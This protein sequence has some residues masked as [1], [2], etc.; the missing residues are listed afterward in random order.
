MILRELNVLMQRTKF[1]RFIWDGCKKL[2]RFFYTGLLLNFDYFVL[3]IYPCG[4]FTPRKI[5]VSFLNSF[6]L[7]RLIS[8]K[9]LNKE[10]QLKM[11]Y[12]THIKLTY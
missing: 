1:Q 2:Y 7:T 8:D 3:Y 6:L 11:T 12:N 10:Q 5:A 4:H 9:Q